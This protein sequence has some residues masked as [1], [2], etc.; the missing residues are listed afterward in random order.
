MNPI[1]GVMKRQK[2]EMKETER[3]EHRAHPKVEQI[4]EAE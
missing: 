2:E 1:L 4:Q 3:V